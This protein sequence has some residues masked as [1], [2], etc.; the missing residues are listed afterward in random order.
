M[1]ERPGDR[2]EVMLRE[3]A[4]LVLGAIA[5]RARDFAEADD[6]VQEALIAA[7]EQWPRDGLPD[8]PR[9]W[10]INVA[11]RKLTDQ[12][13]SEIA[14]RA[15]EDAVGA[16]SAVT[17]Q[18]DGIGEDELDPDDTLV[19]LFMSCHPS[20]T[21]PSAIA[22]TLRAV[23]G[24]TTAE[25]AS[26][27]LVPEATIGQRISRAK[28][29]I[30]DSGIP[31][32]LP[33]AAEREARLESVLRVLY[34]IFNEGYTASSGASLQRVDLSSE[35]IRLTRQVHAILPDHGDVGGLL[36]LMLLTDARRAARSNANGDLI[37]LDEQDR[38]RWNHA[39]IAE[40]IAIATD[41][42]AQGSIGEYQ[43][44]AAIAALHDEA[45]S[46]D[47]TDWAQIRALY[48][49]IGRLNNSPMVKL[50]YAIATA[51]VD[52]PEA[53]LRLLDRLEGDTRLELNHRLTAVRA[54]LLERSGRLDEATECYRRAAVMTA[55]QPEQQYLLSRANR[56][57]E[58]IDRAKPPSHQDP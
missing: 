43:L 56:T 3:L 33:D 23:G 42:M 20:L 28:A 12:I 8:N 38:T 27:F 1:I 58:K 30:R 35:A 25:I 6:A 4:P 54:H 5:R 51:M 32:S 34:L 9:A 29:T 44:Q 13:R 36:A 18:P 45:D 52:G 11:R 48:E 14:R 31:F 17:V 2:I 22:L 19:L 24:L 16:L 40:G 21:Q 49:M 37:P 46:T 39:M 50:N 15:R 55:N 26:A 10:L 7:A 41:A 47:D 57:L 53:G